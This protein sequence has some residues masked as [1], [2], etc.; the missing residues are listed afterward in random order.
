MSRA[1]G[2]RRTVRR[3]VPR[4]QP[5]PRCR[6]VATRNR[7]VPRRVPPPKYNSNQLRPPYSRSTATPT[8]AMPANTVNV[9]HQGSAWTNSGVRS[10]HHSPA[11][12]ASGFRRTAGSNAGNTRRRAVQR[13]VVPR[14]TTVTIG[15]SS[16][17]IGELSIERGAASVRHDESR[18]RRDNKHR[19][20]DT[21][22]AGRNGLRGDTGR[23][24]HEPQLLS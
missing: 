12:S 9:A 8:T 10:R 11:A 17:I 7:R 22:S 4:R 3:A 23:I 1:T 20:Y 5:T 16:S 24:Y 14:T 18:W 13:T 21:V 6:S 15:G 19:V 2:A